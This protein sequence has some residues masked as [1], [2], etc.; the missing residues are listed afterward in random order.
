MEVF[1]K[2]SK[3][4]LPEMKVVSSR[5]VSENPEEEVIEF[6]CS[7]MQSKGFDLEKQRGFGYDIPVSDEDLSSGKRGYEYL[8]TID[9]EVECDEGIDVKTIA[10]DNYA[11]MRIAEPF[12]A[13]FERI[14]NGWRI[15]VGEAIKLRSDEECCDLDGRYCLEEVIIEGE[16]TYMDL[17]LPI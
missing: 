13:P 4:K 10:A 16:A 7:W 12:A 2:V 17:Y 3:A 11:L 6:L 14:G 15:L 5:R 9:G 1:S 8:I